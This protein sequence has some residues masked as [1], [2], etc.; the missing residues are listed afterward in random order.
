MRINDDPGMNTNWFGTMSVA[1]NGRIDVI[2]LDNRDAPATSFFNSALYYSY[3]IDQGETWSG[4]EK[5]TGS[6]DPHLGWPQQQKMGD[7]FDMESD[8]NSANLSWANTFNGEEDVYYSRIT[9][10]I[11]GIAAAGPDNGSFAL[12]AYPNPF[13][14]KTTIRY[15]TPSQGNVKISVYDVSGKEIRTLV[16]QVVPAGVYTLDLTSENLP[17]GYYFCRLD[18][19]SRSKTTKLVRIY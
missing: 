3:S 6:F 5:L 18:M 9:P 16:N 11:T 2:W 17:A 19:G 10:D 12:S 4:N 14:D 8:E 15:K 1:P 7:Y 13:R